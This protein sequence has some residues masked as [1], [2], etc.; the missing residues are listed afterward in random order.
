MG[1]KEKVL[2]AIDSITSGD[3]LRV[4][5]SG[6]HAR[7]IDYN[8][9]AKAIIENYTGSSV[10]GSNQSVKAAL[11]SLNSNMDGVTILRRSINNGSSTSI[12]AGKNKRALIITSG[13]YVSAK[14]LYI[15]NFMST[16]VGT[17]DPVKSASGA[18]TSVDNDG[19]VLV[20][21]SSGAAVTVMVIAF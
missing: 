15:A 4:V 21:N 2:T 6:G 9:L 11:D 17:I 5:T 7:K 19:N 20:T 8:L 12:A 18:Q 13:G 10:A 14:G 1:V 16:G 3:F